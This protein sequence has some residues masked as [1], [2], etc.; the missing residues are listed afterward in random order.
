MI[1]T[2]SGAPAEPAPAAPPRRGDGELTVD[3][4]ESAGGPVQVVLF[5][6]LDVGSDG[7][8]VREP[9]RHDYHELIWIK[10]GSGHHLL[11]G[12][13]VPVVPGTLTEVCLS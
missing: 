11:D 2:V 3:R 7:A 9:H 6:V 5:D 8:A 4:L 1:D 10:E 13:G 12:R